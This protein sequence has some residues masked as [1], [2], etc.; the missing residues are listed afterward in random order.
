M[1]RVIEF[2]QRE[3]EFEAIVAYVTSLPRPKLEYPE[4]SPADFLCVY[5]YLLHLTY[6]A[7]YMILFR[8]CGIRLE[9]IPIQQAREW[10][11][12]LTIPV[13]REVYK[14]C[15]HPGPISLK[16]DCDLEVRFIY[17]E[18]NQRGKAIPLAKTMVLLDPD[19]GGVANDPARVDETVRLLGL[20]K[21]GTRFRNPRTGRMVTK[22]RPRDDQPDSTSRRIPPPSLEASQNGFLAL[23][24]IWKEP[25]RTAERIGPRP[26]FLA[27]DDMLPEEREFWEGPL[28]R[29][30]EGAQAILD[31]QIPIF[32]GERESL[33]Q[34]ARDSV[35][36]AW[37]T[38]RRR[39]KIRERKP[40][41]IAAQLYSKSSTFTGPKKRLRPSSAMWDN[42]VY[43]KRSWPEGSKPEPAY[44]A[45]VYAQ[46]CESD[47]KR[48]RHAY[49]RARKLYGSRGVRYL[50]LLAVGKTKEE[51]SDLAGF[52]R[53]LGRKLLSKL[54]KNL[55]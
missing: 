16:L 23:F 5:I 9:E 36:N 13:L 44:E 19:Y 52:S 37:A 40:D 2:T 33:A 38:D 29:A 42:E 31:K 43:A 10:R 28:A 21:R 53:K 25:G 6:Q 18:M 24:E 3:R 14:S 26:P 1:T 54:S 15:P 50:E 55:S 12:R 49:R 7:T 48:V 4:L 35:F 8:T 47:E 30:W 51:A 11:Y 27:P 41:E 34:Q 46:D 22:T 39:Q 20:R 32:S 17:E 45:L